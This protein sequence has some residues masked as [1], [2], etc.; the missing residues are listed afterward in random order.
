MKKISLYNSQWYALGII[1]LTLF[2]G[3]A[4]IIYQ[5]R[6]AYDMQ[7]AENETK[8]PPEKQFSFEQV[9]THN[10]PTD[11]W[12]SINDSVYDLSTWVSRHP[13]GPK[14]IEGLCGTDGSDMFTRMHEK[15]NAAQAA[16]VLLKIG[17]LE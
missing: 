9:Q 16:L 2:I 15:S 4:V 10:T 14:P 8:T 3:S 12:S 7:Q 17:E 6:P 1:G 5:G 13:G 11:C